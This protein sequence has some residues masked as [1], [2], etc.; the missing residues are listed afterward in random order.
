MLFSSNWIALVVLTISVLIH[1]NESRI[2][3]KKHFFS[4]IGHRSI[5]RAKTRAESLNADLCSKF[6]KFSQKVLYFIKF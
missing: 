5:S 6:S 3:G 4:K 2:I 1:L